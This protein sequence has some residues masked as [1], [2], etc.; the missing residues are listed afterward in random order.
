[1][2]AASTTHK[3]LLQRFSS[4]VKSLYPKTKIKAEGEFPYGLRRYLLVQQETNPPP[5]SDTDGNPVNNGPTILASLTAHCNIVFGAKSIIE[6]YPISTLCDPLLIKALE[7]SSSNGQQPQALSALHGLTSYVKQCLE[8]QLESPALNEIQNDPSMY[9][10]VKAIATG[11]PR[12]GHT[13]VGK[14]THRDAAS[15]WEALAKE[16]IQQGHSDECKLYQN[17]G[18]EMIEIE[19]LADTKPDY[20]LSAGGTMARFIFVVSE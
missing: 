9:A 4:T 17:H 8:G 20:L 13:V 10:A 14:G 3:L 15:G 7:D 18:G 12:P 5:N 2:A 1:M 19:L 16:F 11:V 6:N